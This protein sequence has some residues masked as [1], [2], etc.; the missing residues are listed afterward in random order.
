M[1]LIILKI[2]FKKGEIFISFSFLM[3]LLSKGENFDTHIA[4]H[5]TFILFSGGDFNLDLLMIFSLCFWLLTKN[6]FESECQMFNVWWCCQCFHQ[7]GDCEI[8]KSCVM[9]TLGLLTLRHCDKLLLSLQSDFTC[10]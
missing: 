5:Y 7:G 4:Q 10:F 9:K 8:V 3:N 2:I 1:M 6:I